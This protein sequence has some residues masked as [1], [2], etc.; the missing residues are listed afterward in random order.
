MYKSQVY[1]D[2]IG[3]YVRGTRGSARGGSDNSPPA[4]V[5]S[6]FAAKL[7]SKFED[8]FGSSGDRIATMASK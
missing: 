8:A 4:T 5:N 7:K 1:P 2:M 6:A 3:N